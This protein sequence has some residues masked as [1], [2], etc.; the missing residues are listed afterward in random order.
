MDGH[1]NGID[2]MGYDS[3]ISDNDLGP[4]FSF[5]RSSDP[6]TSKLSA[7]ATKQVASGLRAVFVQQLREHGPC[8]ANEAVES[9][10]NPHYAESVRKRAGECE[11][12]GAVRVIG[13]RACKATGRS[14]QVYEVIE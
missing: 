13:T 4:L 8:T 7:S 1:G 9:F 2:R 3:Y 5:A 14:A 11:K 6:Q 12:L 10:E